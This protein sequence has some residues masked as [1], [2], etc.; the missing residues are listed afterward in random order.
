MTK[1]DFSKVTT[2]NYKELVEKCQPLVG[3]VVKPYNLPIRYIVAINLELFGDVYE[4]WLTHKYSQNPK[5]WLILSEEEL[6][7]N[8]KELQEYKWPNIP[9][10]NG[11][12]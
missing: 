12:F 10:N 1:I 8:V 7:E 4:K 5:D 3:K 9:K 11:V 6:K 2:D